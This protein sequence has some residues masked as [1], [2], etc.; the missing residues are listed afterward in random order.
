MREG[1]RERVM[2]AGTETKSHFLS[3]VLDNLGRGLVVID[4]EFKI[5]LANGIYRAR[6]RPC[7]EDII[8]RHCYEVAHHK[9]TPCFE[10]GED[11]SVRNVLETGASK[12]SIHTHYD[13]NG[14]PSRERVEAYPMRDASGK[15][16]AIVQIVND[17]TV[18]R[19]R[20]EKTEH[21]NRT[22]TALNGKLA[23]QHEQIRVFAA[24]LAETEECERRRIAAELHDQVGQNLTLMGMVLNAAKRH[25]KRSA[26]ATEKVESGLNDALLLLDQVS[27]SIRE[28]I[29]DLRPA[30]L[31][32]FGLIAAIKCHASRFSSGT[33][34]PLF[35]RAEDRRLG[36][37]EKA[38]TALFRILQ[39]ALTNVARHAEAEK[40]EVTLDEDEKSMRLCI[41]DD[42]K[43]FHV[44]RGG[45]CATRTQWGL[46]NMKERA[47]VIGGKL[48]IESGSGKGTR[49]IVEVP[50]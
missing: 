33:G 26:A 49:I 38:K 20:V 15:I 7:G 22:L 30:L 25:I 41:A 29:G 32:E 2:R 4:P 42:G 23:R 24:R 35:V 40:V 11:C 12:T 5:L 34:I 39:E 9:R 27:A 18:Q 3:E 44:S 16:Q 17:V 28:V 14:I 45:E 43:G 8:G 46:V 13:D 37:T 50:R 47:E 19:R 1:L 6:E 31:D 48:H 21:Q 10:A 36:L